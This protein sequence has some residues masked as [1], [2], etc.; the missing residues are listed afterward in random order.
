ML[1]ISSDKRGEFSSSFIFAAGLEFDDLGLFDVE[2]CFVK[3][4]V[5]EEIAFPMLH[6]D[7]KI[8][9]IDPS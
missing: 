1:T 9:R 7:D 6:G 3:R 5:A 4:D 8:W 2:K